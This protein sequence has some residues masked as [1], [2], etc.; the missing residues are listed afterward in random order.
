MDLCPK[1]GKDLDEYPQY[2]DIAHYEPGTKVPCVEL[3]PWA[4]AALESIA[5]H[6][7]D[8]MSETLERVISDRNQLKLKA[9]GSSKRY[10]MTFEPSAQ[11]T[12]S[13]Q[14]T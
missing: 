3:A 8:R 6:I 10:E 14:R 13:N 9:G 5:R 1:C 4:V 11:N 7:T 2:R 12:D